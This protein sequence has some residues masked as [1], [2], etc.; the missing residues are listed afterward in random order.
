MVDTNLSVEPDP[1][2]RTLLN[3][4]DQEV[5]ANLDKTEQAV[6]DLLQIVR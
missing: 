2:I 1:E 6:R 3:G 4:I 5:T